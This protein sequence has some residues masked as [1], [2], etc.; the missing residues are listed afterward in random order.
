LSV[1]NQSRSS[2][3]RLIFLAAF[4]VIIFR[5][6][7]L[8]VIS[9]KYAQLARDNAV[10]AKR[11]Y[12]NRGVV[13][14]RK[15][16]A[17]LSNT[18]MYDL[19]ITP[20]E[21][22]GTDT[23]TLCNLLGIDTTE[24]RERLV[25]AIIKNGR[26]RPSVFEALLT[27]ELYARLDE[28]KY[29]FF[30]FD[31]VKRPV[32]MYPFNT[33][34]NIL[35]YLGE[36]DSNFL[37]RHKDE[38]YQIG[39]FTG[40]DGIE[41]S[42]E[43][44]LMGERGVQYLIKDNFNRIK[45]SYEKGRFDT[46][47]VAGRNLHLGLDVELQQLGEKLMKNK[48][49][50]IVAIDP[51]TGAILAMVSAPTYE[52]NYLTGPDRKRHTADLLLD[53]RQPLFNRAVQAMYSPGSTFKTMVG[54]VGLSEGVIGPR[55]T[56]S[57]GGAYY[58][59]KRRMGCHAVGTFDIREAIAHSC[60]AYFATVFRRT[61]DQPKFPGIDSGLNKWAGYMN[62]FGLGK[63]LGID[64][65]SEKAGII[66]SAA[67]YNKARDFGPGR[68]NSCSIVSISIGQGEVL[69][70]MVQVANE[71][72]Y[73]ANKGWYI[74]PHVVDSIEGGDEFHLL[75]K[76][77]VKNRPIEIADSIFEFIHDGMQGV[78]EDGTASAAKVPGVV[79]CGKTG[80]VENAYKG[81]KQKDHAFFSAFAPRENPRIAIAVI[82]E[83]AGF[84][85]SSAAPIASL[86][87]EKYLKD[88]IADKARKEKIESI[89]KLNLMP[90]RI[91][92][93]VRKL[94]SVRHA[95]D[96]AYL[97]ERGYRIMRDSLGLEDV[98][99]MEEM[100]KQKTKKVKEEDKKPLPKQEEKKP[101][102]EAIL[103][104]NNKRK[105]TTP[106]D[107]SLNNKNRK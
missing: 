81:V 55:S 36:V 74:T 76:Y 64:I 56:V 63:R 51:K 26:F 86:M 23:T 104:D 71:M 11:E 4:I 13:F 10:Y 42:Y 49:G 98:E 105:P 44:V 99:N 21:I 97:I 12:P 9:G 77:K 89:S 43:K 103:P 80:T 67:T 7:Q 8:Q 32:R 38:G 106:A 72:A 61:V 60:N 95:G 48:I 25:A 62:S 28:N 39:D 78:M 34:A 46:A 87:I 69:A 37:K 35:G 19:M 73:L 6:F 79:V 82:C 70:T 100:M 96:T 31:L 45:G 88:S 47:A 3:V 1:L 75:D 85:A 91:Y 57:C 66:P 83:N 59:C 107:D 17:I 50:S 14:D 30:G 94:D 93:E 102:V 15:G 16:K 24:F 27:P 53:P 92:A 68:W 18:T 54:I 101:A 20:S 41:K 2:V 29:K 33:G 22:K 52:P 58:G 65:P 90:P 5:L 84:G 40:K